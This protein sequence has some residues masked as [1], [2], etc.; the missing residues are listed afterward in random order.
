MFDQSFSTK[1][2]QVIFDNENR[3]GKNIETRFKNDFEQSILLLKELKSLNNKLEFENDLDA[4]KQLYQRKKEIKKER[5]GIISEIL[6]NISDK[7]NKHKVE[8]VEGNHSGRKIYKFEEK[9]E[10][11]LISK[12]VQENINQTYNVK[13]STR[14]SILNELINLLEDKFPKFVIKTDI[15]SFYES[16]PQKKL[17]DKIN[18]DYLLSIKTKEFINQIFSSY[19]IIT[20]QT[21]NINALGIPRGI[22]ISAYLSE[23]FMRSIDNKI[24]ELDDVVYYARYVDDIIV[25]FVPQSK[26]APAIHFN[27]YLKSIEK[28]FLDEAGEKFVLNKEKTKEYNLLHGITS[29]QI[30]KRSYIEKQFQSKQITVNANSI[31]FLG[32]RI[33]SVYETNTISGVTNP[34]IS[35]DLLI[36]LS[37]NKLTKYKEKIKLMFQL[38]DKKKN[39]NRNYA[40]KLLE[41]RIRYLTSNTKLKNNKDKVFVGIYYSNPFLNSDT[42]LEILQRSLNYYIPRAGLTIL[43]KQSLS[44][45]SFVHGFKDVTFKLLPLQNKKY[46]NYNTRKRDRINRK[47]KGVIQFGITEINSI[48]KK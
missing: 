15:K 48:W 38:F 32:Y 12:K 9:I 13:Q 19:N 47:N 3:K 5:E 26:N 20:G 37:E 16:I 29:I 36:E 40:F 24:R 46:K 11:F 42:S 30:E 33:G 1:A 23:L 39:H 41:A 31:D 28:I 27:E 8:I 6:D 14:Y 7:I 10:N 25:V 45:Y 4:K 35:E 43:E 2:F 44:R 34:K 18:T 22:G 17:L 21:N